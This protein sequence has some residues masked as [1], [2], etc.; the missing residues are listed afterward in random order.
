VC[1]LFLEAG[2]RIYEEVSCLYGDRPD[3]SG[4]AGR[5]LDIVGFHLST[6]R[7]VSVDVVRVNGAPVGLL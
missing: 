7:Q 3:H 2:L 6:G 5:R 4:G 1:D